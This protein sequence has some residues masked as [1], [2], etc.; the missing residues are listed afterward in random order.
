M[1]AKDQCRPG[2]TF[3]KL[4]EELISVFQICDENTKRNIMRSVNLTDA[5]FEPIKPCIRLTNA[6]YTGEKMVLK[7]DNFSEPDYLLLNRFMN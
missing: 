6:N 2:E 3:L 4:Y 7:G 1:P 5:P